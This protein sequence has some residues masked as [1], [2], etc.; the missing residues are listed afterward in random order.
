[1]KQA[2]NTPIA[3]PIPGQWHWQ[4][5]AIRLVLKARLQS[6]D[7]A[8]LA[9][10]SLA[11]LRVCPLPFY[12]GWMLCDWQC[13]DDGYVWASLLYGPDGFTPLD[14]TSLPMHGHNR[15]HGVVLAT[16]SERLSYLRFFTWFVRGHD[17]PFEIVDSADGLRSA[18]SALD[19]NALAALCQPVQQQP[20]ENPTQLSPH[21]RANV[22]FGT[23]LFQ[24]VFSIEDNGEV[25]M[26]SDDTIATEI[27]RYPAL[28]FDSCIRSETDKPPT[29]QT[30]DA[31]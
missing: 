11:A 23:T 29:D 17:M 30:G 31:Q 4:P 5:D 1:M 20:I 19:A 28:R 15:E 8:P 16:E 2:Q 13:D 22:L 25:E 9:F 27:E 18:D 24:S 10:A 6:A 12:P 7:Y 14:G 26:I 3:P 21:W